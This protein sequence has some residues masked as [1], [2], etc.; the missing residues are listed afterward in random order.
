MLGAGAALEHGLED[1]LAGPRLARTL[2]QDDE[3]AMNR[4]SEVAA[5]SDYASHFPAKTHPPR[6]APLTPGRGPVLLSGSTLLAV[7]C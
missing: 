2:P 5:I 4:A 6:W 3:S 7:S 1:G